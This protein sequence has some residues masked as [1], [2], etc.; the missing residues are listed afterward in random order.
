MIL[1]ST[2]VKKEKKKHFAAYKHIL[3]HFV[4]KNNHMTLIFPQNKIAAT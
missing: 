1:L 3:Y 4:S 2:R